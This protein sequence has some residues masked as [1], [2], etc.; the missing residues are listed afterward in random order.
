MSYT[1]F[2]APLNGGLL[3]DAETAALFS[4]K[5]DLDAMLRFE[6]ALVRVQAR[7]GLIPQDAAE[8]VEQRLANFEPDIAAIAREAKR[9]GVLVP[10]LVRQL[11]DHVG[12]GDATCIHHRTTSQDVVDS[13]AMM[14]LRDAAALHRE[15]LCSI[16]NRLER[17]AQEVG[18][19]EVHART[20]MQRAA[21]VPLSHRLHAWRALVAG[22]GGSVTVSPLVQLGGPWGADYRDGAAGKVPSL[23]A[24]ELGLEHSGTPWHADRRPMAE[25]AHWFT[26]VAA[27][28]AKI[29][30]DVCVMAL[31]EVG[32]V[33][34]RGGGRSSAM[35]H[36]ANPVQ[37]EAL[38]TLGRFAATLV[39]GMHNAMIAEN[40]RSGAAWMLEWMLMPQLAVAAGAA[41]R[42]TLELLDALDFDQARS[43]QS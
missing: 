11:R 34:V 22:L 37:A 25:F 43:S 18:D 27:G 29:G 13:A 8:R 10:E 5:A 20:R 17:M 19:A 16:E 33:R 2:Q 31:D 38:V 24:D 21:P 9:D 30:A 35:P 32:E 3:G 1:P 39:G 23:L 26:S 28:L 40:E 36:K 12:K 15:R 7:Q 4:V 41:T 42:T 6:I 14:R